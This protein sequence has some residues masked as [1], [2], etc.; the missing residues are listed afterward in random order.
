MKRFILLL[1]IVINV[2]AAGMHL[3]GIGARGISM[4]GAYRAICDDPT[5]I[6]WNPAGLSNIDSDYKLQ[7]IGQW[8]H[9][10]FRYT[11]ADTLLKTAHVIRPGEHQMTSS[12]FI[13]PHI[14]SSFR[15]NIAA[16]KLIFGLGFYS[17]LGVASTWDV[18]K[19]HDLDYVTKQLVNN[20]REYEFTTTEALPEED[21]VG[22]IFAMTGS[23]AIA[24]QITE[25]LS[26]G[27]ATTFTYSSFDV[28]MP[29]LDSTKMLADTGIVF[30]KAKMQSLNWGINAGVQYQPTDKIQLGASIK[31]DSDFE[32]EGE[33]REE[34]YKFYNQTLSEGLGI[35]NGGYIVRPWEDARLSLPRPLMYGFGVGYDITEDITITAD[36][37]YTDWEVLDELTV[38]YADTDSILE[39]ITVGWKSYWRYSLGAEWRLSRYALR[40]GVFYEP[41]PPVPEYQNLFLPDFNDNPAFNLGFSADYGKIQIESSFEME[42]FGEL[43]VEPYNEDNSTLITNIPGIYDGYVAALTLSATYSF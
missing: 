35:I 26:I 37:S 15:P 18:M 10:D 4:G 42:Y 8:V 13:V 1:S 40:G 5:S 22:T 17:P 31:Y 11:P 43:D 3:P 29:S 38:Y 34:V 39:Q 36:A 6:Y 9:N 32:Y 28:D 21:F 14:F 7:A 27:V 16:K 30:Q 25:N 23:P 19:D 12:D 24:Y 20:I 41:H 2:F 33:F